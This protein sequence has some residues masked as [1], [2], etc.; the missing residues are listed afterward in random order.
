MA[1]PQMKERDAYQLAISALV[2]RIGTADAGWGMPLVVTDLA[3]D[4]G[5][6]PTPVREALA[7]LAGEG[8]I[9]HRPGRGYFTPSPGVEDI[10]ELYG[11]HRR[12]VLWALEAPAAPPAG[13]RP[14]AQ[15]SGDLEQTF[16]RLVDAAGDGLLSR[17]FRRT[18]LQLRPV[19]AV[20]A[21]L[22]GSDGDWSARLG[23]A[24]R[25]RDIAGAGRVCED[26]HRSRSDRIAAVAQALRRGGESIVQ[27]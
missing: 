6:S 20:E 23:D 8:I 1:S 11:L 19:R 17:T 12:L 5:L 14:L 21:R 26:Y 25:R 3:G 10:V 16:A 18:L 27:I 2:E 24:L 15:E 4:L 7:R 13:P 9:E 22:F